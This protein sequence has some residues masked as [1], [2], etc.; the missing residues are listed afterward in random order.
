L[1]QAL[2]TA[3]RTVDRRC[4][5]HTA[6]NLALAYSWSGEHLPA[7]IHGRRA[8]E[9]AQ[10]I[11]F[12]QTAGLAI[13]NMGEIYRDE[14]D[15][16]RATRCCAY[17]L[18]IAVELRD[19]TSVADQLAVAATAAAAEGRRGEAARLLGQ[20]I[21]LARHLDAPYL[22]CGWLHQAATLHVEQGRFAAAEE[23]NR[24]ALAVADAYDERNVQV[25]ASVLAQRLQILLGREDAEEAK[26]T[27]LRWVDVW[28]LPHE[29]ALILEARWRIDPADDEARSA[30]ADLYRDLHTRTPNIE[31]REAYAFLTGTSLLPGPPL[32]PLPEALY[33]EVVD[34]PDLLVQVDRI[35]EELTGARSALLDPDSIGAPES[36]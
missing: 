27:L 32:P 11:G 9:V 25:R 20:A 14:G 33:E 34:L 13:G 15:I 23:L 16:A 28:T 4:L 12:R 3:G 31:Y 26:V 29:R 21:A 6:I 35:V 18:R 8:F 7:L 19:W 22:L 2:D 1:V 30:A 36:A 17:A 10:E 5:L 24:E